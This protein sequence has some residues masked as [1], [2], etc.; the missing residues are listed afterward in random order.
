VLKLANAGHSNREI[1]ARLG[2][3]HKTVGV[4]VRRALKKAL[5]RAGSETIRTQ[6]LMRLNVAIARLWPAMEN[7]STEPVVSGE[8]AEDKAVLPDYRPFDCLLRLLDRQAKLT[9][10]DAPPAV[11]RHEVRVG[12]SEHEE[13]AAAL[14]EKLAMLERFREIGDYL[15]RRGLP[16]G[17]DREEALVEEA[18]LAG[19]RITAHDLPEAP[20]DAEV[21]EGEVLDD[22]DEIVEPAGRWVDGRFIMAV[23]PRPP[24]SGSASV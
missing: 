23:D 5:H 20:V 15:A 11:Q 6:Q 2:I 22:A 19:I 1:G 13:A 7:F 8:A 9:G 3:S 18:R 24:E 4:M 14:E 21:V 12:Q 17:D 10:A 16:A